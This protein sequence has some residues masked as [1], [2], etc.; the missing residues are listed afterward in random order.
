M[1]AQGEPLSFDQTD[2]SISGHAIETRI[3]AEDEAYLPQTGIIQVWQ[4][5]EAAWLRVDHG[6]CKTQAVSSFY[7]PMLAKCIVWADN[8]RA[9][10]QRM[11]WALEHTILLGIK[12]NVGRLLDILQHPEFISGEC[13]VLWLE[14]QNLE[15]S[16]THHQD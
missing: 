2:I 14:R 5:A 6:L 11:N 13:D 15:H 12:C 7:D 16:H 9:A 1:V 8:R 4:P 10:I 3:Y